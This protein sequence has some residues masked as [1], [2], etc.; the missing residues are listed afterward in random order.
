MISWSRTET[1]SVGGRSVE[2]CGET[3]LE[4]PAKPSD[5]SSPERWSRAHRAAGQPG[6]EEGSSLTQVSEEVL[7]HLE[8]S[9]EW[10]K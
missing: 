1:S 8:K 4:C 5:L 3:R 2:G 6:L 9:L 7:C 10:R